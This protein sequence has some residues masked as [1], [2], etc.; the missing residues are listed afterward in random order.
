M[1]PFK[2]LFENEALAKMM[3]NHFHYDNLD[4]FKYF[5]ISSNAVYPYGYNNETHFLRLTPALETSRK[6]LEEEIGFITYLNSCG[7]TALEIDLTHDKLMLVEQET[8]FG[9]YFAVSF[10]GVP[11]EIIESLEMHDQLAFEIGKSL[12]HLHQLSR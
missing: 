12:G 3:V 7:Y 11:G 2:Y 1:L 8:P 10:K 5:R 6:R 9:D 4:Y